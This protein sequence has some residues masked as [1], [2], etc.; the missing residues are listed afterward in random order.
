[1]KKLLLT[2]PDSIHVYNYLQLVRDHFDEV[3]VVVHQGDM[4][5]EYNAPVKYISFSLRNPLK[6][7]E[8]I[9][10]LKRYIQEFKP[11]VIHAHQANS[12][13]YITLRA[14]AGSGIPTVVTAWG[15]DILLVPGM[16]WL[17]RKM[18]QYNLH[19]AD[20]FTSDS[21][22]VAAQMNRLMPGKQLD[23]TIANFGIGITPVE[24]PKENIIYSNRLHSKLYRID[25]V[26]SGFAKFSQ[27]YSQEG[28]KLVIAGTGPD[29]HALEQL[30]NK[31]KL[32]ESVIFAGWVDAG[33][34]AEYYSRSKIFVSIPE[35]D[36]TA[37]S[38]LEAMAAGCLP[39]VSNLPANTEW[40]L[41][42][43]NGVIVTNI[44]DN[45]FERAITLDQEKAKQLNKHIIARKGTREVN[46][47]KFV[48]LYERILQ[49]KG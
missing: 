44:E 43:I 14:A 37:I 45:F 34:N 24:M 5:R 47:E 13:S 25:K 7:R 1:M 46:R 23:I 36:G 21:L 18:V 30:V 15:S 11:S 29:T 20:H 32:K 28:W 12:A 35:S 17:Y 22:H 16:G 48:A 27:A 49:K 10:Q 40:V 4:K 2:G 3:L 38:L 39:V 9:A 19:H 41:D 31:M 26:I 8:N 33:T 42:E 6:V